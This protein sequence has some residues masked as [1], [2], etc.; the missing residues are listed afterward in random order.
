[1]NAPVASFTRYFAGIA[2][3]VL[4]SQHAFATEQQGPPT[5]ANDKAIPDLLITK[6][7]LD[8]DL[9]TNVDYSRYGI[10]SNDNYTNRAVVNF[11]LASPTDILRVNAGLRLHPEIT[12]F[13]GISMEAD[14]LEHLTVTLRTPDGRH[15]VEGG[16]LSEELKFNYLMEDPYAPAAFQ[17]VTEADRFW[18]LNGIRMQTGKCFGNFCFSL[19]AM[20]GRSANQEPLR[21]RDVY[22]FASR[23]RGDFAMPEKGRAAAIKKLGRYLDEKLLPKLEE[24]KQGLILKSQTEMPT[25]EELAQF[26]QDA[27]E[28]MD[29]ARRL[30]GEGRPEAL[31]FL[32]QITNDYL[33]ESTAQD[34]I[35]RVQTEGV[36]PL[37]EKLH[38]STRDLVTKGIHTL[39]NDIATNWT[40]ERLW[41]ASDAAIKNKNLGPL[42]G[43]LS[44]LSYIPEIVNPP[45]SQDLLNAGAGVIVGRYLDC[46]PVGAGD[47][48][49]TDLINQELGDDLERIGDINF[50][51][52]TLL[53]RLNERYGDYL[54]QALDYLN[55]GN[56][57]IRD[58]AN[59]PA[60][61]AACHQ[62]QQDLI[63]VVNPV[64]ADG[65]QS[66]RDGVAQYGIDGSAYQGDLEEYY[67]YLD[68]PV[69]INTVG[70]GLNYL[71]KP[72]EE[73]DS[74]IKPERRPIGVRTFSDLELL[75]RSVQS[76][77]H[78]YS[79]QAR[80]D[81]TTDRTNAFFG[82]GY[83]ETKGR[84][85]T[86]HELLLNSGDRLDPSKEKSAAVAFGV[87]RL[88]GDYKN[89]RTAFRVHGMVVQ[90][91]LNM[92]VT[93]LRERDGDPNLYNGLV[94]G[95]ASVDYAPAWVPDWLRGIEVGYSKGR[96]Y[97][98][99]MSGVDVDSVRVAYKRGDLE[100]VFS[101]SKTA[102]TGDRIS[103]RV[104]AIP[105]FTS[106]FYGRENTIYSLSAHWDMDL[107]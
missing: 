33:N 45:S 7:D 106:P 55:I 8:W 13:P 5:P 35:T 97:E 23:N 34:F 103:Q 92:S 91:F 39:Q 52:S 75:G 66:Y 63:R 4:A 51:G 20:G 95:Y 61:G 104:E 38:T 3:P 107:R 10:N 53:D 43:L 78:A 64:L 36:L 2:L 101:R 72:V 88:W 18:G 82:L 83:S 50:G 98:L 76:Q 80:M 85:I 49:L 21:V 74:A 69:D 70:A 48:P 31:E 47:T 57:I 12:V 62:G 59:S 19:Y 26:R 99:K 28:I 32:N 79:I 17:A 27:L 71:G 77:E 65:I 60:A 6:E 87:S 1:M 102:P 37:I 42:V 14:R 94:S 30:I 46:Q 11:R 22:D 40:D 56:G 29:D 44:S 15:F 25:P 9:T 89:F 68:I 84:E 105:Y 54:D 81:F 100:L 58:V 86:P 73:P 24:L 90:D 96:M 41:A 93:A 67:A 16:R